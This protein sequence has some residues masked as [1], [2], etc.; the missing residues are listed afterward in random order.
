M[1]GLNDHDKTNLQ[2]TMREELDE[3]R[4]DVNVLTDDVQE[5]S[6]NIDMNA[7]TFTVIQTD[8]QDLRIDV[9]T[10]NDIIRD[11]S[12]TLNDTTKLE[13]IQNRT[14][15]LESSLT[16]V[17]MNMSYLSENSEDD[18]N[19]ALNGIRKLTS[20]VSERATKQEVQEIKDK[21]TELI[22]KQETESKAQEIESLQNDLLLLREDVNG[23]VY[24]ITELSDFVGD[25][26]NR[27]DTS[28]IVARVDGLRT[29]FTKIKGELLE[30]KT[31]SDTD[32]TQVR[33]DINSTLNGVRQLTNDVSDRSKATKQEVQEIQDKLSK[34]I[35][36]QEAE[37]KS[38]E[39]KTLQTDVLVL[40]SEVNSA[41]S[42]MAELSD[43]VGD[44][45][46]GDDTNTIV[47]RI[48]GLRTDFTNMQQELSELHTQSNIGDG[49]EK[50]ISAIG[51][52]IMWLMNNKV[53][54]EEMENANN[55]VWNINELVINLQQQLQL[56][57]NISQDLQNELNEIQG[58]L[59]MTREQCNQLS[60]ELG[61]KASFEEMKNLE[62]NI[63]SMQEKGNEF[64]V[65]LGNK[66]ALSEF[67]NLQASFR[68]LANNLTNIHR[69]FSHMEDTQGNAVQNSE[70]LS[71]QIS[72][73]ENLRQD[74]NLMQVNMDQ[75]A[76]DISTRASVTEMSEVRTEVSDLD[77]RYEL[78]LSVATELESLNQRITT[79]RQGAEDNSQYINNMV[80]RGELKMMISGLQ[81]SIGVG[82]NQTRV[83]FTNVRQ[84]LLE[85]GSEIDLMGENH[86][87][88]ITDFLNLRMEFQ[89]QQHTE[90][91]I[92]RSDSFQGKGQGIRDF[93]SS[94]ALG[95]LLMN[96]SSLNQQ[97][98]RLNESHRLIQTDVD[99]L[100]L[101]NSQIIVGVSNLQKDRDEMR[102][103]IQAIQYDVQS[104]KDRTDI[105]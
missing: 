23:C 97:Y 64:E 2:S 53:S 9:T 71:N 21:V 4:E 46:S 81:Q 15:E 73:M 10:A 83:N 52:D 47:E 26:T 105:V 101:S 19:T 99:R 57:R 78:V 44:T 70:E 100:T 55:L 93:G 96:V 17:Q 42:Q 85:F 58:S 79:L 24:E 54:I 61:G 69:A 90:S 16:I 67:F 59:E 95:Q 49:L 11:L 43:L 22:Q 6:R 30:F 92:A 84:K 36:A 56:K 37:S 34:M 14:Q 60:V 72:Q 103:D 32:L 7:E 80:P 87:S 74:V 77:S 65:E 94:A 50:R 76:Q 33:S 29:D 35:Q 48:N 102:N 41:V 89:Q 18:I 20:D 63:S 5:I 104:I 31:S 3:L 88:M 27:D 13:N 40:R 38:S 51:S 39:I 8:I 75:M 98:R 86:R 62:I 25:A 45:T 68:V 91:S 1:N 82:L 28:T 12:D 66:V